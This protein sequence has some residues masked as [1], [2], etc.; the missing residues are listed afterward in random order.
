MDGGIECRNCDHWY[1][2]CGRS[3]E[4]MCRKTGAKDQ[5]ITLYIC[6]CEHAVEVQS[7]VGGFKI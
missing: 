4:G 1:R 6:S 7:S 3:V 2:I 5:K